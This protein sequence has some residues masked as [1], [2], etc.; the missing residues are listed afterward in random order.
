MRR[1][2]WMI[3]LFYVSTLRLPPQARLALQL[4]CPGRVVMG[5]RA[6]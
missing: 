1:N 4:Y 6:W 2:D 5:G 3:A